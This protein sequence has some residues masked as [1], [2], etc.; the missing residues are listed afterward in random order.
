[1]QQGEK[2]LAIAE[3]SQVIDANT[4]EANKKMMN[5]IY[6]S[7]PKLTD[8]IISVDSTIVANLAYN[9]AFEKGEAVY[10]ARGKMRLDLEDVYISASRKKREDQNITGVSLKGKVIPNPTNEKATFTYPFIENEKNQII[11]NDIYGRKVGQYQLSSNSI[12]FNISAYMQGIYFIHVFVNGV[13]RE[14]HQLV[15]IK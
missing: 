1:M 3:N 12:E 13:E 9:L 6:L 5:T 7:Y 15:I 14:N 2:A 8:S 11:L 4:I 10:W